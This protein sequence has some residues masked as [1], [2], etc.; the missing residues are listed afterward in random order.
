MKDESVRMLP[1]GYVLADR[2]RIDDILG[3]GGFGITYRAIDQKNRRSV[4]VKELYPKSIVERDQN[5]KLHV[6][7]DLED[8][9]QHIK[10]RFIDEALTIYELRSDKRIV[11]L[12]DV[13]YSCGTAYYVMELLDGEDLKRRMQRVGKT[14]WNALQKPVYDTLMILEFLHGKGLIHRDISPDNIFVL[15]NGQTKLIDFGSMRNYVTARHFTEIYKKSFGPP[16]M[17][18]GKDQGAWTDTFSL[19]ASIYYLLSGKVPEDSQVRRF[20]IENKG[21]D[22]L[23][24]LQTYQVAAPVHVVSAVMKGLSLPLDKRYRSANMF[25][26]ALFPPKQ[27][28]TN[29]TCEIACIKGVLKGKCFAITVGSLLRLGRG[30]PPNDIVYPEDP[31]ISK[32]ISHEH[33]V[34]Y[35]N[36][37]AELFVQDRCSTYGTF[38]DEQRLKPMEWYLFS[39]QQI[40]RI[41]GE[42]YLLLK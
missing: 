38:I 42:A 23:I 18:R 12:Y 13:F 32:G 1:K 8:Y 41:G 15:S 39:K 6:P 16:E 37:R 20:E 33:C 35:L 30:Y 22:P 19:A 24:P 28:S 17:M 3:H 40:L 21:R 31:R 36:D 9:W 4:A 34:F 5:G 7:A 2:Y 11:R 10:K 26:S 27:K 14:S 29:L 25:R